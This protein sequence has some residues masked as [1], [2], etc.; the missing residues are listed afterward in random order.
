MN[1][2]RQF[3][4][5]AIVL[6]G[7]DYG[8]SDRIVTFYTEEFGKV[9]GIAKGARRSKRRF[10]NTLDAG[11][12][13][14]LL[15]SRK[16]YDSLALIEACDVL[17]HYGTIRED[18]GKTLTTTA[19]L[20]LVDRFTAEG[21]TNEPLF[22][23][24]RGFL[25]LLAA[26][27]S[28]EGFLQLFTVRLLRLT[29]YAPV[30]DRCQRCSRPLGSAPACRF[31][32]ERGGVLCEA[33]AAQAVG[34]ISIAAGTLKTLLLAEALPL[35]KLGRLVLSAHA[36]RESEELLRRFIVQL[37]GKELKTFHVAEE[38]RKLGV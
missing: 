30:L 28:R 17:D 10:A 1:T 31:F 6:H 3:R 18:L 21:K 23:T 20:E 36:G 11:C 2:R 16:G 26:G 38:I 35:E 25:A 32:P 7:L 12:S 24:L 14:Q 33:C 15:F 19:M 9:A 27:A 37:T 13:A 4:T 8:E 34:G 29:G 22:Q 5:A